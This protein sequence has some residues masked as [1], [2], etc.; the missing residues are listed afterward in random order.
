MP[1]NRVYA[2]LLGTL[3]FLGTAAALQAQDKGKNAPVPP[4]RVEA[5]RSEL[6]AIAA[7]PPKGM[8]PA[9]LEAVKQRLAHGDFAVGDKVLIEVIGDQ[10][11]SDTFTVRSGRVLVLPSLPTLSL[12]GVLRSESDSVIGAFL[13]RFLRDPQVTVTP[14]I[15]LGVLGGVGQ[16]G[17][18]DVPAQSLLSEVIM[19]AG[20]LGV[21]GDMKRTTVNR[22]NEEVLDSKAANVA[23]ANGS[24]L[25]L[26][27]MQS[28]DNVNVGISN[29][30]KTLNKVQIITAILAIPIMILTI[31]ALT[32]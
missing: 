4:A 21:Y 11:Y 27:N 14:M 23:I 12:D 20:G 3:A 9:D 32:N 31:S 30:Q 10:T 8:A 29:P 2:L 13:A 6:E 15:R 26:L 24:T 25:D 19:G 7:N 18:Y 16:P 17:Y 5:T 1:S 28:G 22:G